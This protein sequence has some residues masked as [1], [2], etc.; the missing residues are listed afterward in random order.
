MAATLGD[1]HL[2]LSTV[3]KWAAEFKRCRENLEDDPRLGRPVTATTQENIDRI[4][5]MVMDGRRLNVNQI[6]N[7]SGISRE[8][9]ENILHKERD[10]SKMSARWV[11]RL[12]TSDQKHTRLIMSQANLSLFEADPFSVL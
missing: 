9:V 6:A 1:D 3:Q 7:T 12:M 4:R 5:H 8:R 10:I 11:L 2:A